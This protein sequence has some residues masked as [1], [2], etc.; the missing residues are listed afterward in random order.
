MHIEVELKKHAAFGR[1]MSMPQAR[2][3]EF[4]ALFAKWGLRAGVLRDLFIKLTFRTTPFRGEYL[5]CRGG[6]HYVEISSLYC[7]SDTRQQFLEQATSHELR[8]VWWALQES[9]P[10]DLDV[11][12]QDCQ[13][14][15]SEYVGNV[16]WAF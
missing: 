2:T 8:H 13:R 12:E 4:E 11:E 9:K 3:N 1:F 5:G 16:L 7:L 15:E 10:A 6:V 14:I